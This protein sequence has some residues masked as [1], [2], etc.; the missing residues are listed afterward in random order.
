MTYL[1][2]HDVSVYE[3]ERGRSE[4]GREGGREE[5]GRERVWVWKWRSR[6][7][8]PEIWGGQANWG[9]IGM[10]LS[11]EERVKVLTDTLAG[12]LAASPE[13]IQDAAQQM[14]Q[15]SEADGE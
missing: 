1:C 9:W 5:G 8:P 2:V 14:N 12:F 4:G 13:E 6:S 15:K 7:P 10:W 3:R 11:Q